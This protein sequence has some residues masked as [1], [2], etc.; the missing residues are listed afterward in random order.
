MIENENSIFLYA[1]RTEISFPFTCVVIKK[2]IFQDQSDDDKISFDKPPP[3]PRPPRTPDEDDES[4]TR[5][6]DN[7]LRGL[8]SSPMSKSPSIS[9]LELQLQ[10]RPAPPSLPNT[11]PRLSPYTNPLSNHASSSNNPSAKSTPT[12][13]PMG[14]GSNGS[15]YLNQ[16]QNTEGQH[17]TNA[18]TPL[19]NRSYAFPNLPQGPQFNS[20]YSSPSRTPLHTMDQIHCSTPSQLHE[21]IAAPYRTPDT[22][23]ANFNKLPHSELQAS[24]IGMLTSSARKDSIDSNTGIYQPPLM[25]PQQQQQQQQRF[26]MNMPYYYQNKQQ[27]YPGISPININ[28]NLPQKHPQILM[29]PQMEQNPYSQA[30]NVT[31]PLYIPEHTSLATDMTARYPTE[32]LPPNIRPAATNGQY[33]SPSTPGYTR[34]S[35]PEHGY[36]LQS[37]LPSHMNRPL[38]PTYV[39]GDP[40]FNNLTTQMVS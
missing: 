37:T 1:I 34:M 31:S 17:S 10:A 3:A 5:D 22:R 29:R 13:V 12:I 2:F 11:T 7:I 30:N 24:D 32:S 40:R 4:Q 8:N 38:P 6:F 36:P 14:S 26:S 18:P 35:T 39:N 25:A 21:V 23:R 27:A 19:D 16:L 28:Y 15:P 9:P 20:H 33:Y